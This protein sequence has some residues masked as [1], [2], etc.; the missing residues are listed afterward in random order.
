MCGPLQLL[1]RE[2]CEKCLSLWRKCCSNS[3]Q[4]E[5]SRKPCVW[6][7]REDPAQPLRLQPQIW[8]SWFQAPY[9]LSG[10]NNP[11]AR[12][13]EML[14]ILFLRKWGWAPGSLSVFLIPQIW[15][16]SESVPGCPAMAS[17]AFCVAGGSP[18]S[19]CSFFDNLIHLYFL[20]PR[21]YTGSEMV[22]SVKACCGWQTDADNSAGLLTTL[23]LAC[24]GLH[25]SWAWSLLGRWLHCFVP[26]DC[27]LFGF[28]S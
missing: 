25:I 11:L 18:E 19:L 2:F 21:V 22:F 16:V 4:V 7:S 8:V 26:Y 6:L 23:P 20:C 15:M 1:S 10:P 5:G 27:C 17:M 24:L 14:F 12:C 28:L 3:A 9:D 13:G